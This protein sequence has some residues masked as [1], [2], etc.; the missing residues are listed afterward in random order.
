VLVHKLNH[1]YCII[2]YFIFIVPASLPICASMSIILMLL[3]GLICAA[4]ALTK[5]HRPDMT[6]ER[7]RIEAAGG[8]VTFKGIYSFVSLILFLP[9]ESA[10][11]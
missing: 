11:T 1:I 5:D 10:N 9:W 6:E 3:I 4:R 2:N 7:Q 8:Q